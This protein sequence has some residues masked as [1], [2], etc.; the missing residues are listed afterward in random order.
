L[1]RVVALDPMYEKGLASAENTVTMT[2]ICLLLPVLPPASVNAA[3]TT[4]VMSGMRTS[5][6]FSKVS[7]LECLLYKVATE[8]FF[9]NA[10][11]LLAICCSRH[12]Y[13]DFFHLERVECET[14]G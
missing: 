7:A 11:L 13:L 4:L 5:S 8:F 12:F 1:L 10:H 14:F 6:T 2:S 3:F 9:E